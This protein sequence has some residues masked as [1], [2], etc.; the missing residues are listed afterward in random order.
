M[1]DATTISVLLTVRDLASQKLKQ[2]EGNM[3]KLGGT[4]MRNR[5]AIG[6]AMLG[7]GAAVAG[8]GVV[9]AK[10]AATF[11]SAMREVNSLVGLSSE[12]FKQ[13]SDQ[14]LEL[15]SRIGVDAV[16]AS[17]ALYQAISAGVPTDNVMEFM[18]VASKAAIAGVTDTETAVD[19][20]TT[21]L[22]AFKMET[23]DAQ[24]VA[25]VMFVAVKG[26]KTTFDELAASMFYAAPIAA[27]M[28][29]DF[30][31]VA[32][33]A[34][35][36]TKQ[37][38]PTKQAMTSLRQAF[39]ALQ[40]PTVDME[41]ALSQV[42]V[43]SGRAL[44][45]AH[46][47]QKGLH[48]LTTQTNL[49]ESQMVKAF[50]SVEA[51][52]AVLALTGQ[53]A[54]MAASDLEASY[55]SMGSA[56]EAFDIINQSVSRQWEIMTSRMKVVSIQMGGVLLPIVEFLAR[57]M[58]NLAEKFR[59]F[60]KEH[61]A[62]VKWVGLA[63]LA[64]G[65]LLIVFGALALAL[66]GLIAGFTILWGVAFAPATAV[67]LGVTAAIVAAIVIWKKWEDAS[68]KVRIVVLALG[69]A[70]LFALGPI[71]WIAAAVM[72]GIAIWKNW[73]TVISKVKKIIAEAGQAFIWVAR[74]IL[75]AAK[76][77]ADFIPGLKGTEDML[78]RDI[79]KL[80][81]M[82]ASMDGWARET[83]LKTRQAAQAWGDMEDTN[84]RVA[85][86]VK[87][88]N[89][90]MGDSTSDTASVIERALADVEAS[91]QG[92]ANIVATETEKITKS[93]G[94][95]EDEILRVQGGITKSLNELQD[96]HDRNAYLTRLAIDSHID[97]REAERDAMI[98]SAQ[99][100]IELA[101]K[102]REAFQSTTDS[103]L[104]QFSAQGTAWNDLGGNAKSVIEALAATTDRSASAITQEFMKMRLAGESWKDMLL[105]L[106]SDGVLNL[107]KLQEAMKALG[108]ES[109]KTG[110]KIAKTL[111]STASHGGHAT[112]MAPY[113]GGPVLP[114]GAS[115]DHSG[116]NKFS[117]EQQEKA[118][119]NWSGMSDDQLQQMFGSSQEAVRWA[120]S[121]ERFKRGTALSSFKPGNL[122]LASDPD[123]AKFEAAKLAQGGIVR[124]PTMALVGESGPEAV[125]P[126][127]RGGGM[128]QTNHFHFHGAV[129]GVED[130]KE[131][132]V[133]AVRDHAISGGFSGVF[134][135]A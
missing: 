112:A 37:G 11:D 108:D 74:Q 31:S 35:T 87:R 78:Q 122:F 51:F 81:A 96:E 44:L 111:G 79:D 72:A 60:Q 75:V 68:V 131:A 110:D 135:E 93:W 8:L 70:I 5:R 45:D 91:H 102:Q 14:T 101:N 117:Q 7:I 64:L 85:E 41:E 63:S 94:D 97:A 19:G 103:L 46:G 13:L 28:G 9:A 109:A 89:H 127:G 125:I 115:F 92:A 57:H 65:G 54:E 118:R 130:L 16:G 39:V 56:T 134:A 69:A 26:G 114:V 49:T 86:E 18:E 29:V 47:L 84:I 22:N 106:D 2:V 73:D 128:G 43:A 50:G 88:N 12:E 113:A 27:A 99:A 133:E 129:Y 32:A 34:A 121:Q 61:P 25:D 123:F 40:K 17:E 77:I 82:T 23:S 66:P 42:G 58:A 53:N 80:D 1:A 55:N 59:D 30:E 10:S 24:K 98:A 119:M 48:V 95:V 21:V 3:D 38:I 76:A 132:V 52:Q 6:T 104:F 100:S 67:I 83:D 4:V 20:L 105:R 36:M 107:A 33:A 15:S 71:G 124:H 62:L 90:T 126:L 116:W 120:A